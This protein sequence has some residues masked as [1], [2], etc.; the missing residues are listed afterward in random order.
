MQQALVILLDN[1]RRTLGARPARV[2]PRD[3]ATLEAEL[4]RPLP[5]S[6]KFVWQAWGAGDVGRIHLS[7]PREISAG[8]ALSDRF[9]DEA[10]LPFASG[11]DGEAWGLRLDASEDP[12]VVLALDFPRK[13][14]AVLGPLSRAVEVAVLE[15][16]A[17][18]RGTDA[19]ERVRLFRKLERLD[20]DQR[21]RAP[22][23]WAE[24]PPIRGAAAAGAPRSA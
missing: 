22:T 20:A 2:D 10:L 12:P 9:L 13:L 11:P 17:E 24:A 5:L 18:H 3:V 21:Y 4:G 6:L 8:L 1:A 15:A 19:G 16:L 7:G 23:R 14:R